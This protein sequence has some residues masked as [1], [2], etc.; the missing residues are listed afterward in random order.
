MN[1][2]ITGSK[3]DDQRPCPL[4]S[5]RG[6][7]LAALGARDVERQRPFKSYAA[8]GCLLGGERERIPLQ[9]QKRGRHYG[10]G[11]WTVR[12]G[13]G[14]DCRGDGGH[15]HDDPRHARSEPSNHR[16][17][18]VGPAFGAVRESAPAHPPV[19]TQRGVDLRRIPLPVVGRP[20]LQVANP[21]S[22][23][24]ARHWSSHLNR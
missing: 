13:R 10:T 7:R 8:A 4:V 22:Y 3:W 24:W 11:G 23:K 18:N 14:V 16:S 9:P 2:L 21:S 19:N 15:H 20:A 1:I 5:R 12:I 17:H 6:L